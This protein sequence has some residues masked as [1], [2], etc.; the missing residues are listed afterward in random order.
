MV[1]GIPATRDQQDALIAS[2]VTPSATDSP[3]TAAHDADPRAPQL[4]VVVLAK[5]VEL[6]RGWVVGRGARIRRAR[7]RGCDARVGHC[8]GGMPQLHFLSSWGHL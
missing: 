8:S 4:P 5:Y 7:P 6:P 3:R 1:V 2:H